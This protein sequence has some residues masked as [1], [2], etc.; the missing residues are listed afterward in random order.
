MSSLIGRPLEVCSTKPITGYYRDGYCKNYPGDS[1]SHVVC[2]QLTDDFLQYTKTRGNNLVT[3]RP[4]F[5]GLKA[6]QRWC[7][8]ATRWEEARKAGKAPPVDMGASDKSALKFNKL[9]TY[10]KHA[11]RKLKTVKARRARSCSPPF[12]AW[13]GSKVTARMGH[14]T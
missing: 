13:R 11:L 6:G 14:N 3:P 12:G 5:P 2:A 4:G 8:C 9:K 1:G 7:L 10:K